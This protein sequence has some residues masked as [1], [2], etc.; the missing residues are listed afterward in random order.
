MRMCCIALVQSP[1]RLPAAATCQWM[2]LL[3][4]RWR[5]VEAVRFIVN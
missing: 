5:E 4:K 3:T 2:I 1:S